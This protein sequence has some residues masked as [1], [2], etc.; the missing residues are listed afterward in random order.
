MGRSQAHQAPLWR[1]DQATSLGLVTAVALTMS[2]PLYADAVYYR[3]LREE[4]SGATT[5]GGAVT[6]PPFAFIEWGLGMS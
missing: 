2:V 4:L 6:R 3:V 5:E 1:L